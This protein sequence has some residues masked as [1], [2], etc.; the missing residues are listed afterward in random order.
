VSSSSKPKV[1]RRFRRL[2]VGVL[3]VLFLIL[4]GTYLFFGRDWITEVVS[5]ATVILSAVA[6]YY[7]GYSE[8]TEEDPEE[9]ESSNRRVR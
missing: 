5:I 7:F 1:S 2:T 8:K 3:V 4:L 6:G 9:G